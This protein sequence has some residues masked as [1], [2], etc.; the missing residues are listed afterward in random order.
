MSKTLSRLLFSLSLFAITSHLQAGILMQGGYSHEFNTTSGGT[1]KKSFTLKNTGS[2]PQEVKLYLE[3]YLFD[4]EKTQFSAM[5][6]Q[7]NPRSNS[8]WIKFS[9][10]HLVL[11]PG[12]ERKIDYT[13]TV[14]NRSY[15]GTYWSALI[16]EPIP[17]TSPESASSPHNTKKVR[18]NIRQIS[19]HAVQIVAQ[20]GDSGSIDLRLS[21]PAMKRENGQRLFSLDSYNAGTRWIKPK[22]WLDL[23]NESGN[24]VGKFNGEG[25]R[26][27]PNTAVTLPVDISGL[28]QGNYSGLFVVDGGAGSEILATDVNLTI[29]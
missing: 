13:M 29:K 8:Q 20:M 4:T 19:R 9:P 26:I 2:T 27:Y 16:I 12:I 3:D 25:S 17:P 5:E 24:F 15:T 22:V 14:P 28:K 7:K 10:N 1:Y 23:Y 6:L 11:P 21:N 18:M